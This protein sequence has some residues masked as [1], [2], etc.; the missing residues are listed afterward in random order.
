MARSVLRVA[1]QAAGRFPERCVLSGVDTRHAVRVTAI[2]WSGPV[3]LLG[4]PGLP[5]TLGW[6]PGR[7]TY[8][9][10]L[11]V[12]DRVWRMWR[13]RDLMATSAIF[14]G[15]TFGGIGL[16]AGV[17]ELI[18]FGVFVGALAVVYRTRAHHDYW[19]TCRF[20]PAEQ[21]IVVEPTHRKFDEAARDLFV[22]SLD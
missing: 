4:V 1:D 20:R 18:A 14:A 3:W 5:T 19:V 10:A 13:A 21:I 12:G 15:A 2:Q 16:A 8:A 17:A 22:R 7:R 9:V 11:P 6:L